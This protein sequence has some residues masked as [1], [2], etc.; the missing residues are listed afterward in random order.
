MIWSFA[1][2][3]SDYSAILVGDAL[4]IEIV[5]VQEG[6]V[7]TEQTDK[8]GENKRPHSE[9]L[10]CLFFGAKRKLEE[11]ARILKQQIP[12]DH[13]SHLLDCFPDKFDRQT[14][15]ISVLSISMCSIDCNP[16]IAD[17][18]NLINRLARWP[19]EIA[20]FW[21]VCHTWQKTHR[22]LRPYGSNKT[23]SLRTRL[24]TTCNLQFFNPCVEYCN[25][26]LAVEETV[27][28][29]LNAFVNERFSPIAI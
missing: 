1:L 23:F 6:H 18:R 24:Y 14:D 13:F 22:Q 4:A 29:I 16:L 15:S 25:T 19:L 10:R 28:L 3:T 9:S 12:D 27:R 11:S 7:H 2:L 8:K 17:I 21:L 20:S 5:S 26:Q